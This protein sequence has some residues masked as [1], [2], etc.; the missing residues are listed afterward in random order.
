MARTRTLKSVGIHQKK[1]TS[2]SPLGFDPLD[3]N[4]DALIGTFASGNL[5][6]GIAVAALGD[7]W[8]NQVVRLPGP[9]WE[10]R[11]HPPK[12]L[13]LFFITGSLEAPRRVR[14]QIQTHSAFLTVA[15]GQTTLN[16]A[17]DYGRPAVRA[18]LGL[19]RRELP[20]LRPPEILWEGALGRGRKGFIRETVAVTRFASRRL[21]VGELR[22]AGMK[23]S[24]YNLAQ[25]P[26]QVVSSLRWLALATAATEHAEQFMNLRLSTLSIVEY[27]NPGTSQRARIFSYTKTMTFGSGGGGVIAPAAATA[28]ALDLHAAYRLRNRLMHEGDD[29]VITKEVVQRLEDDLNTLLTFELSKVI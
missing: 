11:L 23:L 13:K 22:A 15:T 2:R 16:A 26:G 29:T 1:T 27:R 8:G 24:K 28:L 14:R 25:L 12:S 6:W 17:R 7:G 4:L 3:E 5:L 20:I 18:L 10:I 21:G 9:D 19:A